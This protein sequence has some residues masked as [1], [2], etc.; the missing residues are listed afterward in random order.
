MVAH[1]DLSELAWRKSSASYDSSCVEVAA[2]AGGVV[3]R[4][5]RD[6]GKTALKFSSS[7]WRGFLRRV[8]VMYPMSA[9]PND[10]SMLS[11]DTL[12]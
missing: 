8:S 3:V 12:C 1:N 5:T 4:D 9:Q 2:C 7:D 6:A 10:N 11:R